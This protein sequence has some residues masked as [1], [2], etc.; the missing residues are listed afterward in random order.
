MNEKRWVENPATLARRYRDQ[1]SIQR[2]LIADLQRLRTALGSLR[3]ALQTL[4]RDEHFATLLRAENLDD[5]PIAIWKT[6][7][8]IDDSATGETPGLAPERVLH[9]QT[10]RPR[11]RYELN[12]MT[13]TRQQETAR[14]MLG[15]GCFISPYV[16]A[17]VAAC[18]IEQLAKPKARARKIVLEEPLRASANREITSMAN[19]LSELADIGGGHLIT[20]FAMARYAERLLRNKR[21]RRYLESYW[22]GIAS[23]LTENITDKIPRLLGQQGQSAY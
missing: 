20:V 12:R 22:P 9:S 23:M 16:R 7:S 13:T 1:A 5:A 14:L 18:S 15:S 3:Q 8:R 11:V 2:A 19:E 6:A 17:I 21:V 4:T 10:L